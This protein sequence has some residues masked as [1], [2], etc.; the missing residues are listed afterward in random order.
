[1]EDAQVLKHVP[2]V[3]DG[4]DLHAIQVIAHLVSSLDK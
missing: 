1:M 4:V 2:V 3:M